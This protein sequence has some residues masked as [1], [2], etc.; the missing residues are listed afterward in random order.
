[1]KLSEEVKNKIIEILDLDYFKNSLYV[2]ANGK[3]LDKTKRDELG[4]F[5]TP[6]KVC[7]TMLE[8]F[9]TN[10][11][12]NQTIL[13]PCCGSGNLLIAMLIAGA[14]IDKLY[15]NEYDEEVIPTCRNRIREAFKILNG[16]YPTKDEFRD[17][18]IHRGNALIPDCLTEF[19]P[20]YDTTLL[21]EL[22]K[23]RVGLHGGWMDNPEA[24]ITYKKDST[25]F[26]NDRAD[27]DN[28]QA[29][30]KKTRTEETTKKVEE[31]TKDLKAVKLW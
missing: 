1:M 28:K 17:W 29:D 18:Q 20:D 6:A 3:E 4:Q 13:D 24:Y 7:I 2:D 30:M 11:F 22:L 21:A 26:G 12:K 15:G 8:M 31:E 25:S 14:D 19:G 10:T 9:K 5:Y 16:R 23:R 27:Y